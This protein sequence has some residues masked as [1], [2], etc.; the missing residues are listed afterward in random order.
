MT[1]I[2][3]EVKDYH[4]LYSNS[5]DSGPYGIGLIGCG[6]IAVGRHLPAYRKAGYNVVACCDI[7]EDAARSTAEKFGIPFWTTNI[8]ELLEQDRVAIIDMALHPQHRMEVLIEIAKR[9]RPVLT[10][11][12]LHFDL[13]EAER[14]AE[15]A[16]QS[17]IV[18]GVNQ[19]ARWAPSHRALRILLD[20]GVIGQ[21]YS[22]QNVK[23]TFQ[24]QPGKW[25]TK[26]ENC[27]IVDNGVHYLDICRYFAASPAAGGKEWTRLHCT[28]AEVPGQHA[29][30]PMI[31]SMNIEFGEAGGR[32]SLMANLHFNNIARAVRSHSYTWSLDGTEG[33]MW[34]SHDKVWIA[35]VKEPSTI[36]EIALEGSWFPDAFIGPMG[37]LMNAIALSQPPS[38]TPLDNLNT[39]AMTSAAVISSQEGRVVERTEL[40]KSIH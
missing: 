11:K 28:T 35:R 16:D 40:L 4:P 34:A 18:M 14:L 20:R 24:D 32:A 5:M 26:M 36:H 1:E 25:W 19:Q 37:D 27:N 2:R 21:L 10:Q 39:V 22:I 13:G 3:L 23:R 30:S 17:G 31:Y 7:R 15:F 33:S 29:V 8:R 6:G 38:V 12:P 9:P